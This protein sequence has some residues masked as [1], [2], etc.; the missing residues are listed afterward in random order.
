[1]NLEGHRHCYTPT[2]LVP[3]PF[4]WGWLPFLLSSQTQKGD[5]VI[6]ALVIMREVQKGTWWGREGEA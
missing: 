5:T 6:T 4:T 1:M 2:F 3:I